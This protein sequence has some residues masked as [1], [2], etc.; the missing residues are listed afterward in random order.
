MEFL[1][2]MLENDFVSIYIIKHLLAQLRIKAADHSKL[3]H[4][5]STISLLIKRNAKN[6]P[7]LS[8]YYWKWRRGCDAI[9]AALC[10]RMLD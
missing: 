10:Y 8:H 1:Q 7:Y 5:P 9:V 6:G 4:R 2:T 3:F